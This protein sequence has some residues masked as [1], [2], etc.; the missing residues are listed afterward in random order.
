MEAFMPGSSKRVTERHYAHLAP[1]YVADTIRRN[2]PRLTETKSP[3]VVPIGRTR[4]NN[5]EDDLK[6]VTTHDVV[7]KFYTMINDL[8]GG[9]RSFTAETRV[10]FPYGA[11]MISIT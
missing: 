11:P 3:N 7:P 2:F 10:R 9:W 5:T 6:K 8:A 1:N 4:K